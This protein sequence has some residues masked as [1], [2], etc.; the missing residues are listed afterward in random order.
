VRSGSPDILVIG[1]G[2]S[3]LTSAICLAEAGLTVEIQAAEAP[4]AT[5]SMVAGALW[6]T[7]LVGADDRVPGW[8]DATRAALLDLAPEPAAGVHLAR[9]LMAVGIPQDTPP[10]APNSAQPT[11]FVPCDPAELPAGYVA[12]WRLTEVLVS[13]PA[14]LGYLAERFRAAG[15]RLAE[16]RAFATLAEA[17]R[18]STAPV[19]VS[20]P[21]TGAAALVPDPSVTPVRGQ[22]VVVANPGISEFFVGNGVAADDLTYVFPHGDI[23]VLGGTQEHGNASRDPDPATAERIVAA[24]TAVEPRLAG[25]AILGHRVGLRPARPQVRLE[26][27]AI[28][29]NRYIVHNYGHGGAGVSLS[30]GCA[31]EAASLALAALG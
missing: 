20:C 24:C 5:T 14:Y 4:Q 6:G 22:I 12:G 15:G 19:I 18:Q 11:Q 7:H 1:A 2:V 23:V 26:A 31:R 27:E 16:P 8:A 10:E 30:W 29:G 17:A 13:M 28:P 9:G 3:G 21:G 25:A